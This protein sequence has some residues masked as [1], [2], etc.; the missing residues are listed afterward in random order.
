MFHLLASMAIDTG[1]TNNAV[2]SE[3]HVADTFVYPE[4]LKALVRLTDLQ[5][6]LAP[7][8]PEVYG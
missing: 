3:E 7:V 2:A 8:V 1:R 4:I 6:P 5:L